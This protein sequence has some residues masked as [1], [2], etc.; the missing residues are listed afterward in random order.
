MLSI[1]RVPDAADSAPRK[2]ARRRP[3]LAQRAVVLASSAKSLVPIFLSPIYLP[4]R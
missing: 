3:S 2:L 1:L 4:G